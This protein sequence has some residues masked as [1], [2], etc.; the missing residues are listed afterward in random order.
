MLR[1]VIDTLDKLGVAVTSH[2]AS[3]YMNLEGLHRCV[4]VDHPVYRGVR[5]LHQKQSNTDAVNVLT[6]LIY[7]PE[8]D[9]PHREAKANNVNTIFRIIR[10]KKAIN[11]RFYVLLLS[12]IAGSGQSFT[13]KSLI[14][15]TWTTGSTAIYVSESAIHT[16]LIRY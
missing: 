7:F 13:K 9:C 16:A 4:G 12:K 10:F 5:S 15:N 1:Q 11:Y 8:N 2:P 3:T 6:H 14:T